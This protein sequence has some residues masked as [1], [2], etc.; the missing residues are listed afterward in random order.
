MEITDALYKYV[1]VICKDS[2]V[3]ES[4]VDDH[5]GFQYFKISFDDQR[6]LEQVYFRLPAMSEN[7]YGRK[8]AVM[9]RC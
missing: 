2:G 4:Q 6:T 1:K 5:D 3:V 8:S 7:T 9:C